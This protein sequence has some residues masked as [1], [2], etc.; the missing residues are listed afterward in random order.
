MSLYFPGI[1][2]TNRP[3]YAHIHKKLQL[4]NGLKAN[5]LVGNSI[6]ATKRGF[7]N[8]A[9]KSTLILSY[10]VTISVAA[11][12]RGRPMQK[13]V[14]VDRSLTISPES[15]TLVQFIAPVF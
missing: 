5:L 7:I 12:L 14:L 15:E 4:V 11:R 2:L 10:Q 3:V 1:N 9:N 6:L 8:L 13:K